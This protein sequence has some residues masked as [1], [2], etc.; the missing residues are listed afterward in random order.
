MRMN[1]L[2]NLSRNKNIYFIIKVIF[3]NKSNIL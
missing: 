1:I 2:G 3:Y